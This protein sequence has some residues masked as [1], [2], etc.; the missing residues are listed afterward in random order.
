MVPPSATEHTR[1]L[2]KWTTA[3]RNGP[4][5][6]EQWHSGRVPRTLPSSAAPCAESVTDTRVSPLN[7]S[8]QSALKD[9]RRAATV[10]GRILPDCRHRNPDNPPGALLT[11]SPSTDGRAPSPARVSPCHSHDSSPGHPISY[12]GRCHNLHLGLPATPHVP[13]CGQRDLSNGSP[14]TEWLPTALKM[15]SEF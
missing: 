4:A 14:A 5:T 9:S 10:R 6:G 15:K 3:N 13:L 7:M 12:Q 11:P 8:F 2:N 1:R